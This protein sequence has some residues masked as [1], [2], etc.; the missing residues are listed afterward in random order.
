MKKHFVKE[1]SVSSVTLFNFD[2]S[3]APE[4][5]LEMISDKIIRI[6]SIS[7]SLNLS[8]TDDNSFAIEK[9]ITP[10]GKFS[11]NED[12]DKLTISTESLILSVDQTLNIDIY[13]NK[14][15]LLCSDSDHIP[16]KPNN[17]SDEEMK[18]LISEG[19]SINTADDSAAYKVYKK[20]LGDEAFY[21]LGDKTG[22]LNKRGYDYIM[23]NSDN[24]DPHVE[25]PTFRALYKSIPFFIVKR[26]D[27]TFGIFLD[28]HYKTFFDFGAKDADCYSFGVSKGELNYYFIYGDTIKEVVKNYTSLTGRSPI[29]QM[30]TLGYQQARWSYS[31]ENEVLELA[32]NFKK[33]DIP[34]D[35]IHLDID[36]MDNFKV[37][38][39]DKKRF[40]D[41]TGLSQQLEEMGIK[42]VTIIDPGV[43]AEEGYYMYDEGVKNGYFA[44]TPDGE[45]YHNTVWPG[46]SVFPDFTS[47]SVRSW[48]AD[49]TKFLLDRGIHGIW[50]DM[51]E[52][53]SFN[54]PLPDNIEFAGDDH[55]RL[56]EEVHN[57]YGHLMA[58]A[59]YDGL[60]KHSGKRPFI[61]TRACYSG[62]QKYATAW[63]GDNQS[64]WSHLKLAIP[65]LLNLGISGMP[66]VG[67]D[68]GGFGSDTTPELLSRWIEACFLS[69]LFRNHSAKMTRRQEPW[70]FDEQTLE[71]YRK[72]V[73][74]HYKFMPYLYDLCYEESLTGTPIMRPL[75]MEFEDDE[76]TLNCNDEYMVGQNILVA[77]VT[78]QGAT[79]RAVYLPAGTWVDYHTGKRIH[80]KQYILCDAPIDICPIFIKAGSIIP[81]FPDIENITASSV[82]NLILEFYTDGTSDTVS[83]THYQDNGTDFAYE[84]GEYNLY[85]FTFSSEKPNGVSVKLIKNGYSKK[86]KSITA[87]LY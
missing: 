37:F 13:N 67:V 15:I 5:K 44:K 18:Q 74:L 6:R 61:I 87:K 62:S 82:Q 76:N 14:H 19:H 59:T 65:Q 57:V 85:K 50:N 24:P 8:K 77:P 80:G 22:F 70:L 3:D 83:Y 30:W 58:K 28:N 38:T 11:I 26:K 43:K 60:K 41:L 53:A 52:P 12:D 42:L 47:S 32:K 81:T 56:H 25:N 17:L 4:L 35:A 49:K 7:G 75:I 78:E 31:T 84:N 54:G 46:D 55:T 71:I 16:D 86:Y 72:Y 51:N 2:N 69:P 66:L 27:C 64:I 1:D 63:T 79:I 10:N 9:T 29:P 45:I 40:P 39:H 73:K 34:C 23:W 20:M 68:I 33:Y 21:G 36:Y 48:W